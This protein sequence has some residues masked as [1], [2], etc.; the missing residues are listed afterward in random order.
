MNSEQKIWG[1][2]VVKYPG[3][4]VKSRLRNNIERER[5]RERD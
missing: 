1:R 5:E 2:G 4:I 3:V